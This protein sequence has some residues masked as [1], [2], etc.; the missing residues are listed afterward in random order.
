MLYDFNDSKCPLCKNKIAESNF[1][2]I[3]NSMEVDNMCIHK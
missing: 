2:L 3:F 1:I